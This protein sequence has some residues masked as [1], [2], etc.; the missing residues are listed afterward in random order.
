MAPPPQPAAL[1]WDVD[2]TLAETEL[3]GHRVAY[4]R[5]FAE[6]G[7]PWQWDEPRYLQLLETS[8][9]RERLQRH[10]REVDHRG[11]LDLDALIAAKQRHYAR[12]VD[13]GELSLRPGVRALIEEA[14]A[15]GVTQAIVTT[16][17]GASVDALLARLAPDLAPWFTVRVCGEQVRRKKPDP[18]AYRQAL[19]AL[20]LP[21]ALCVAIEDSLAG[22]RSA[23]A[24]SLP[25]VL[26]RSALSRPVPCRDLAE[27]GAA[28]VLPEFDSGGTALTP[29][30]GSLPLLNGRLRLRD[31]QSLLAAAPDPRD[32]DGA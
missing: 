15:A 14:H 31:L 26:V 6:Q 11:D 24:A 7:L 32:P 28:A 5:A 9:G 8:G 3:Q 23:V 20:Q 25:C 2:G 22:L 19:Q 10:A 17:A 12:I 4:N 16:S 1:L 27:A 29:E 13:G 18:E 30:H 21:A